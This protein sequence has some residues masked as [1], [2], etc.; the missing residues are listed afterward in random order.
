MYDCRI[1]CIF[2]IVVNAS[3]EI[4]FSRQIDARTSLDVRRL[5]KLKVDAER[6]ELYLI[7]PQ[8][9]LNG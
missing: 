6:W 5:A 2:V 4:A 8:V 3:P 7:L 9:M 1:I